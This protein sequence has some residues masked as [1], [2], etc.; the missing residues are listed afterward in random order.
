MSL[1][2]IAAARLR[3]VPIRTAVAVAVLGGIGPFSAATSSCATS[4]GVRPMPPHRITD[5]TDQR[6]RS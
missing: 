2:C 5:A 3:V 1:A 4:A 6:S